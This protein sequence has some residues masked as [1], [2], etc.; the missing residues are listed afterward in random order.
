MKKL[1][2]IIMVVFLI[3]VWGLLGTIWLKPANVNAHADGHTHDS[4][5]VYGVAEEGH[6]H[7]L[8]IRTTLIV[9]PILATLAGVMLSAIKFKIERRNQ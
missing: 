3:G 1:D 6:S 9:T 2:R 7:D 8:L 5:D 4:Y